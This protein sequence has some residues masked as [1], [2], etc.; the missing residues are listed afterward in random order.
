MQLKNEACALGNVLI[1]SL[2]AWSETLVFVKMVT[3]ISLSLGKKKQADSYFP[4]LLVNK[5]FTNVYNNFSLF[6]GLVGHLSYL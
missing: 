6:Q 4:H 3:F 2:S 5:Q 1:H